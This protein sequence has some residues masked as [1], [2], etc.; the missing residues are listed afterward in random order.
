MD[1]CK[2]EPLASEGFI[3]CARWGMLQGSE[4]GEGSSY[5][6]INVQ[7]AICSSW[8]HSVLWLVATK[9]ETNKLGEEWQWELHRRVQSPGWK[10]HGLPGGTVQGTAREWAPPKREPMESA[11]ES[12][13]YSFCYFDLSRNSEW[14]HPYT[15]KRKWISDP[16]LVVVLI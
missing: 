2:A 4:Q 16:I 15:N 6:T 7:R 3:R 8:L 13:Q 12:D 1:L 5:G 14:Q 9:N 11:S 10:R